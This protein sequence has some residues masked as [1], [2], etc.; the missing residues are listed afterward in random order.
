MGALTLIPSEK[1]GGGKQRGTWGENGDE[2]STQ[3]EEKQRED[4]RKGENGESPKKQRAARG[5]LEY[6]RFAG[7]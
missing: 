1:E 4:Q 6:S 3:R 7:N 5:H 2:K